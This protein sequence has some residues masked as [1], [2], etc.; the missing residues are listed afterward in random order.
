MLQN[1]RFP[2][3]QFLIS[4]SAFYPWMPR[5]R[6]LGELKVM[7]QVLAADTNKR[8]NFSCTRSPGLTRS[9]TIWF[10]FS[11]RDGCNRTSCPGDIGMLTWTPLSP[12]LIV[13]TVPFHSDTWHWESNFL[14][15]CI[16]L[17]KVSLGHQGEPWWIKH[18][19]WSH[20]VCCLTKCVFLKI[21]LKEKKLSYEDVFFCL[22]MEVS[23]DLKVFSPKEGSWIFF[24]LLSRLFTK[25]DLWLFQKLPLPQNYHFNQHQVN[26]K[27][28]LRW[29][30]QTEIVTTLFSMG[31]LFQMN[32]IHNQNSRNYV[33]LILPYCEISIFSKGQVKYFFQTV[34][35]F[36]TKIS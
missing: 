1:G 27:L 15:W 29:N 34:Y 5:K 4:F 7:R 26:V 12:S 16:L 21:Y 11:E 36:Q 25:Y 32:K 18:S 22:L 8:K 2:S 6:L 10:T 28:L 24:M 30:L 20:E 35:N 19:P 33:F 3:Y 14:P 9:E 23:L 13:W 17:V 31:M